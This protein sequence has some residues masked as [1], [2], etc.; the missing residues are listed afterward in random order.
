MLSVVERAALEIEKR[1]RRYRFDPARYIKNVLG[2][3]PWAGGEDTP[4]QMEVITAYVLALRKQLE[5]RGYEGGEIKREDLAYYVPGETIKNRIRVEAG[6]TVGKTKLAAGLVSHFF[7]CF[8]PSIVYA[9]APGYDQINDLLFKEI[10][11]DRQGKPLPGIVLKTPEISYKGNHFVKGRATNNNQGRGTE[12]IQGQHGEYLMFVLDE[13]EG[14]DKFVWDAVESMTSGGI[15]MVLMLANPRTRIS[16][17]Y[18]SRLR[19]DVVNFRISCLHH[20]NVLAG[21]EVIAGGV[22]QQYVENMIDDGT[23]KNALV[24]AEHNPK[25]YTFELPWRPGTIYQPNAEFMF[26][27]LGVAPESLADNVFI[28]TAVYEAAKNRAHTP[29]DPHIARIGVD[30]ARYGNDSGTI[31]V[32]HNGL[33]WREAVI[34]KQD[35][36]EYYVQCKELGEKAV[37]NG[38]TDIQ[39]RIDGGGGYG[40]TCIDNLNRDVDLQDLFERF[41]VIE[42]HNNGRSSNTDVE[43]GEYN[44]QY[45]DCITELYALAGMMLEGVT[46]VEPPNYLEQDLTE[47][48]YGHVLK[49]GRDVKQ[50]QRKDAF[51]E[52]FKRS[53]D[54]GDGCVYCLA[55]DFVFGVEVVALGDVLQ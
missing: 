44:V 14:I 24:V 30:V 9:F 32:R 42:V 13:A 53:P 12:R 50:L 21:R 3:E 20:P 37:R 23:T 26:R 49:K 41:E 33:V 7:D 16:A 25:H 39:Y 51:K 22:T 31:Y 47:R 35:G 55:P 40:S 19:K 10:R 15:S 36:Y 38:V 28:S 8:I 1:R 54:D 46:L 17:F 45:A 5:R 27:V 11:A 34:S 18:R 2:W 52:A 29:Q 6:H 43:S 4:G 48:K